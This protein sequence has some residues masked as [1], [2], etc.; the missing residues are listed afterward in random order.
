[1]KSKGIKRR[2]GYY[3]VKRGFISEDQFVEGLRVQVM[4]EQN[5]SKYI[6]IGEIMKMMGYM[7]EE[8]VDEILEYTVGLDRYKCPHCGNIIRECPCCG[9]DIIEIG[10]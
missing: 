3:A 5:G 7:T 6:P 2:F 1:M 8:Q 4:N 10:M 9:K